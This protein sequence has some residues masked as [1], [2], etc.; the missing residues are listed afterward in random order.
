M[1]KPPIIHDEF[2]VAQQHANRSNTDMKVLNFLIEKF[3]IK[4][5]VD[6]GCGLGG[7]VAIAKELGLNAIGIDGD[8]TIKEFPGLVR[9]DYTSGPLRIENVDLGWS[10]AFIEHIEEKFMHNFMVTF[11][12]CKYICCTYAPPGLGGRHHVNCKDENYWINKFR[13]FGFNFDEKLSHEI[14]T[15]SEQKWI[16][17]YAL[18]FTKI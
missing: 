2:G 1:K 9:H 17:Q 12:G 5:F 10:V 8:P 18:F 16:S 6:I 14:R 13:E 11:L 15:M 3:S 7:Q 4:S